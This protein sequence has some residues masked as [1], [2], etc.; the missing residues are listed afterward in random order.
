[1][2]PIVLSYTIIYVILQTV[3]TVINIVMKL[4]EL[5]IKHRLA[6]TGTRQMQDVLAKY[7]WH[8][9][10]YGAEATVALHPSKKYVLK[11]F[12]KTSKYTEF[13][14]MVGSDP[15]NPHFPKFSRQA[16]PVPGTDH[17]YVRMEQL[18]KIQDYDLIVR[19][20]QV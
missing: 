10:G 18:Q 3:N 12:P 15:T 19:F 13:L 17:M 9:L 5:E 16:K 4:N 7:G 2:S 14:D 6:D 20:P 8:P 11:I 1:M